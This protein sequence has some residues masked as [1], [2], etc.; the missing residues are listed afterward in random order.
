MGH[1]IPVK[2]KQGNA[3]KT[4][5]EQKIRWAEHFNELLNKPEPNKLPNID[6][7]NIQNLNIITED[8]T[9]DEFEA[10]LKT[11]KNSKASGC[12]ETTG[13]MLKALDETSKGYLLTNVIL[14]EI[15]NNETPPQEWRDGIIVILPKKGDIGDSNNLRGITLFSS[16]G[17]FFCTIP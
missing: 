11:V 17:K 8:I 10:A 15:W 16:V 9:R 5:K 4:K 2:E 14:N 12:D 3:L 13:E 1:N 7:T 6:L